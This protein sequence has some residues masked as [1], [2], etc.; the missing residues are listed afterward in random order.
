MWVF[1]FKFCGGGVPLI[2][3]PPK[4][5]WELGIPRCQGWGVFWVGKLAIIFRIYLM[6]LATVIGIESVWIGGH[7]LMRD[8]VSGR[9][10][11]HALLIRMCS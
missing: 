5:S 3:P 11:L 1:F 4:L 2:I 10:H 8:P 6:R 9:C 7:A